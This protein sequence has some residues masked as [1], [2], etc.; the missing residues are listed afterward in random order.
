MRGYEHSGSYLSEDVTFFLKIVDCVE[1]AVAEKESLI[2]SGLHHYSEFTS[3][4]HAPSSRYIDLYYSALQRNG[5]RLARDILLLAEKIS[6]SCNGRICIVS[7]A[8]AGTPIGIL[9]RRALTRYRGREVLHASISIIAGRGIDTNALDEIR[10]S[11][12]IPD[13]S[14]FF[15]DGW[16]G[17][18]VISRELKQSISNY[19]QDRNASLSSRLYVVADLCGEA[20]YSATNQDYLIPSCLLGAT[21][22]GLI[23]RSI[24]NS[25]LVGP[26]DYH[27]CRFYK[28]LYSDDKSREFIEE[29]SLHLDKI[30]DFDYSIDYSP[31][32]NTQ[33]EYLKTQLA[34]EQWR[35]RYKLPSLSFVKPGIGEAT[36]VLLRRAPEVL[37]VRDITDIQVAA[38]V[39]LATEKGVPIIIDADLPWSALATI[40]EQGK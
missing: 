5:T 35:C 28:H 23:S 4:E 37:V 12:N 13:G 7:L 27:A 2:Q 18:G 16:T 14:I 6:N 38:T 17:K 10:A 9:I 21:V 39:Q 25:E 1:I 29:I 20:E 3:P 26:T 30:Y 8:R 31:H 40:K 15:V 24:L 19:N 32:E 11:W 34:L 22:S 36:R 33:N